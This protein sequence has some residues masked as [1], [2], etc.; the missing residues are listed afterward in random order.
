VYKTSHKEKNRISISLWSPAEVL[1]IIS[2]CQ[3]RLE[4]EGLFA[5]AKKHRLGRIDV[6]K[7]VSDRTADFGML[8][9]EMTLVVFSQGVEHFVYFF[10]VGRVEQ[11]ID[12]VIR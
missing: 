9:F 12:H 2:L 11:D 3:V 1:L 8:E 5:D 10:L 6:E 7:V 4:P